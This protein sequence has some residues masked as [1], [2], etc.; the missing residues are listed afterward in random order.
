LPSGPPSLQWDSFIAL[1]EENKDQAFELHAFVQLQNGAPF[2][3]ITTGHNIALAVAASVKQATGYRF[4][5]DQH[6][7]V[8]DLLK[9]IEAIKRTKKVGRPTR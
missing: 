6:L 4:K 5:Y 2:H 8:L 9:I 1:L 7:F 3:G